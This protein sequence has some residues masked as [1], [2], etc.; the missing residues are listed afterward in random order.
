MCIHRCGW[1]HLCVSQ[2]V[3]KGGKYC[4]ATSMSAAGC[5]P[6]LGLSVLCSDSIN[7]E[8]LLDKHDKSCLAQFT[9]QPNTTLCTSFVQ[10]AP[11]TTQCIRP[12][13]WQLCLILWLSHQPLPRCAES[14]QES[15]TIR[16]Q[17]GRGLGVS[18]SETRTIRTL[19][20]CRPAIPLTTNHTS[21]RHPPAN[22]HA[23]TSTLIVV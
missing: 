14:R 4:S 20:S 16:S 18:I 21:P 13:P 17:C 6:W 3:D 15:R 19:V 2:I 1:Q 9:C 7:A 23:A 11:S 22:H 8:T 12:A 5:S 10:F